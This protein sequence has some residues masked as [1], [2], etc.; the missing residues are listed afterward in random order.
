MTSRAAAT[1]CVS[2][3][4]LVVLSSRATA[5]EAP[6]LEKVFI[7]PVK[8]EGL[9]TSVLS[10]MFDLVVVRVDRAKV[11]RVVTMDDVNSILDQEKRGDAVGCSAMSCAADLGGALGVRYLLATRAKKLGDE[12]LFTASLIDTEEQE[13]KNGQG[14]CPDQPS[15][16]E[17]AIATAIG[18]AMALS[19]PS[20]GPKPE[21]GQPSVCGRRDPKGCAKACE[22]GGAEA[23]FRLGVFY[24]RGT[25]VPEDPA[26]A[27]ELYSRACAGGVAKG[28]FN[29]GSRYARGDGVTKDLIKA[30]T[31]Y[32]RACDGGVAGGCFRIGK[33]YGKGEGVA[34]DMLKAAIAYQR[35]CDGAEPMG[36]NDLAVMYARGDG[37][38][39]DNIKAVE[40]YRRACDGGEP[41]GCFNLGRKYKQGDGIGKDAA[42][43]VE[44]FRRACDGHFDKACE[45]LRK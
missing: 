25:G 19:T 22:A 16:Y 38:A 31:F 6:Q 8:G 12:V 29:S 24:A 40:L 2:L 4:V 32:Q 9:D 42:K 43:A 36:C 45:A 14:R 20:T 34:K 7:P 26:K 5:A 41:L 37:L 17:K 23:C 18:E 44:L 11:V 13:S 39:K 30:A 21:A 33:M 10:A 1:V 35:A 3:A 28:C 15:E 27:A